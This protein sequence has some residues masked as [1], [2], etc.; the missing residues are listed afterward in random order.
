VGHRGEP[1]T[2]L[3]KC[4]EELIERGKVKEKVV[5]QRGHTKFR[6]DFADVFDF[7]TPE[8]IDE[9]IHNSKYVITQE[10]SGIGSLCL[11]YRTKFIVM[12]RDYQYGELP[13]KSDMNEDL[14]Y[15][16]EELGYTKVVRNTNELEKAI[17]SIDNLKVGFNFDNT[18]AISTL[19]RLMEE[20]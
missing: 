5:I 16:L 14:H 18:L 1:F 3:L 11:K 8:K 4:V 17:N 7:C 2:R 13:A 20:A 9:L 19:H 10:S 12:P 6:S 15:K